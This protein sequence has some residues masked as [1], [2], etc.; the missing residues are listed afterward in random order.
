VPATSD[1]S[2]EA[3]LEPVKVIESICKGGYDIGSQ[4]A[5]QTLC[6]D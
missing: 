1:T 3:A 4:F 5:V 2:I 6:L